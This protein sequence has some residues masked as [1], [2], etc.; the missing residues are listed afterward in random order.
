MRNCVA[1]LDLGDQFAIGELLMPEGVNAVYSDEKLMLAHVFLPRVLVEE[2]EEEE[3]APVEGE[4]GEAVEGEE[5]EAKPAE[6]D[7]DKAADTTGD[8]RS[9]RKARG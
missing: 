8:E 2:E 5:G 6:G 4:E 7:E 3:E 9:G 1:A